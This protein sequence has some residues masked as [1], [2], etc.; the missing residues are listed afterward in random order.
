MPGIDFTPTGERILFGL[1]GGA[2]SGDGAIRQLLEAR[3]SGGPFVSLAD[4][5]T[6]SPAAA[7]TAGR[8]NR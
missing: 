3:I 5:A 1:L 8:W 7:Q 2:H 6:A 4:S